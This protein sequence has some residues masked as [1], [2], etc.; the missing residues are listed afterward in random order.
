MNDSI[1]IV[2]ASSQRMVGEALKLALEIK[3]GDDISVT[4]QA[5]SIESCID[6]IKKF[7]VDVVVLDMQTIGMYVSDL[8]SACREENRTVKTIMLLDSI[9]E[10]SYEFISKKELDGYIM[11]Y[12]GLDELIKAIKEVYDGEKYIDVALKE[13]MIIS[14]ESVDDETDKANLNGLLTKRE[15]EILILLTTG[16]FNKEIAYKLSISEKTVKNHISNIFKKT[17]VSDRT[18][19]AVY[20]IKNGLVSL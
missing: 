19:A 18:Q 10:E 12:T 1:R 15:R 5:E 13:T 9:T 11:K 14:K 8:I 16:L 2:I 7:E 6:L 4:G 3:A 17:G 20:A